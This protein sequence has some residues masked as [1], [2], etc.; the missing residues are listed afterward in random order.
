M[1]RV[2]ATRV[3]FSFQAEVHGPGHVTRLVE[4]LPV[5]HSHRVVGCAVVA[6][7][8]GQS[9]APLIVDVLEPIEPVMTLDAGVVQDEVASG[10][11]HHSALLLHRIEV[12]EVTVEGAAATDGFSLIHQFFGIVVHDIGA[13]F[14]TDVECLAHGYSPGVTLVVDCPARSHGSLFEDG[15]ASA[16]RWV[17]APGHGR[18][19]DDGRAQRQTHD[20]A[21]E[22]GQQQ[23]RNP[24]T[25][26]PAPPVAAGFQPG[27][28]PGWPW[29]TPP[30][31]PWR[32][33]PTRPFR[34]PAQSASDAGS[35]R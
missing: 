24:P 26:E 34:T 14:I 16:R 12:R 9:P 23:S 21:D 1:Q 33:P 6:P 35:A 25:L 31:R 2:P 30:T 18:E 27:A 20:Q 28:P 7:G 17:P 19:E 32:T 8:D 29:R 10:V 4:F 13:I 22:G 11:P 15:V 3:A 5:A